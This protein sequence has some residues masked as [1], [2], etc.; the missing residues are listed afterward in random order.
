MSPYGPNFTDYVKY[1][2]TRNDNTIVLGDGTTCLCIRDKGTIKRWVKTA[3]HAYR[4]LILDTGG[5]NACI[6]GLHGDYIV[7]F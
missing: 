3:P 6:Q 5:K 7:I 4:L 2:E 1:A